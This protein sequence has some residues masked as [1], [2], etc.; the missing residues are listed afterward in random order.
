MAKFNKGKKRV[1]FQVEAKDAER[2]CLVGNFNEWNPEK[3]PMQKNSNGTWE[4]TVLLAPG[5]YEYKFQ[6][7]GKWRLDT[8]NPERCRNEF[9]TQNCLI[10]IPSAK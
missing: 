8:A 2:V 1:K 7:D 10:N 3:H 4:K 6:V 5:R 9:G